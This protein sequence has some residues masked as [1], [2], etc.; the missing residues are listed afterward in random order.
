MTF[1]L[2]TPMPIMSYPSLQLYT[3]SIS[4]APSRLS[5]PRLPN[6]VN[7]EYRKNLSKLAQLITKHL[8]L[9][10]Q[11]NFQVERRAVDNDLAVADLLAQLL[12]AAPEIIIAGGPAET[13][14]LQSLLAKT[15]CETVSS[16]S[17]FQWSSSD[18]MLDSI[19]DSKCRNCCKAPSLQVLRSFPGRFSEPDGFCK[20]VRNVSTAL[21]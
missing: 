6:H 10:S 11:T 16:V 7:S 12:S 13:N 5:Y 17:I 19:S 3:K 15:H 9:L 18:I 14:S 20:P 4:D 8:Q 1:S 21:H 2:V